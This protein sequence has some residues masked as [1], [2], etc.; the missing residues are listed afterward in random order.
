MAARTVESIYRELGTLM[1]NNCGMA[2]TDASL[3]EAL[4]CIPKLKDEF[5]TNVRVR[6]RTKRSTSHW[7]VPAASPTFFEFGELLCIDALQRTESCGGHFRVESQTEDGEALRDDDN[8]AYVAAWQYAGRRSAADPAQGAARVR[9][10]APGRQELQV[11]ITL[12]VWRQ[13]NPQRRRAASRRTRRPT[14]AS[15]CPSWRCS[16]C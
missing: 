14:S 2:R 4:A 5:W 6:A 15:T 1:W 7:S 3:R 9:K 10:R 8:F 13:K 11:K 12:R 16:T